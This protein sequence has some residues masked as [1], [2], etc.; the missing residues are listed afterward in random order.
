MRLLVA[1][2]M[3]AVVV[4]AGVA[5][6]QDP[7]ADDIIRSLM[8]PPAAASSRGA[9]A[10]IPEPRSS[11][12]S[13]LPEARPSIDLTVQFK[14]GSAE[15]TQAA[16][17]TLDELGKALTS[18]ALAG[19][20]FRVEGHTDT[21]GTREYNQALS[22][23]RAAKVLD[24]LVTKWKVDRANVETVGLGQDHLLVPTGQNVSQPRNRRVTVINLGT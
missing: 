16:M 9:R 15:L 19:C 24:Y 13:D 18:D 3:F 5:R 23:R 21:V 22:E 11:V 1:A 6:A 14:N 10:V 17:R 7:R 8:S 12:P 2:I 4:G 20:R